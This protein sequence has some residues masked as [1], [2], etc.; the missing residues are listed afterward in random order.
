M[1]WFSSL[2]L[3]R[4]LSGRPGRSFRRATGAQRKASARRGPL[5]VEVLEDRCVPS[6][7]AP[8]AVDDW[9][10]TDGTTPVAVEVL[11]ND[12]APAGAQ[13]M[14]ASVS[15]V[16]GPQHGNAT[17]D[18]AMGKIMYTAAPGFSGTDSFRY[19]VRDDRGDL[20]NVATAFVRVNVPTAA[21][22]F[23]QTQGTQPVAID[24]LENDTDP[25]GNEHLEPG[26]VRIV[27]GPQHGN[28]TV[29]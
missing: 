22:D 13:L 2:N 16:T 20:S 18:Q 26:S 17:V 14:P 15:I 25:D 11:A 23:G 21:D 5:A 3:W 27:A 9:T 1:S 10:D 12:I 24:V 28:A 29:D 7:T 8:S 6:A 4:L 19:T